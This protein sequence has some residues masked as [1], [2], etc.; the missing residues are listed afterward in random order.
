MALGS[1]WYGLSP[2]SLNLSQAIIERYVWPPLWNPGITTIL[3]WPAWALPLVFGA[4]MT[5]FGLRNPRDPVFG[6]IKRRS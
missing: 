2:G 6:K 5:V 1:R 3:L 4:A